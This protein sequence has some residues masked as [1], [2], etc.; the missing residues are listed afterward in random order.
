[1]QILIAPNAFKNALPAIDVAKFIL[2]GLIKSSLRFTHTIFPVA[3]GGDDTATLLINKCG[4][5]FIGALVKDPI[6]RKIETSFGISEDGGTAIIE[7]AAASG[8]KLLGHDELDPLHASTSGTGEL[9]RMALDKKVK[10]ILLC[11]GGSATIDGGS[12]ILR[13][14]GARFLDKGNT[15][16][17]GIPESLTHLEKIDLSQLDKRLEETEL[18]ILCDVNNRLLGDQGAAMIFGPQK[19]AG[20]RE[21]QKLEMALKRFTD[22]MLFQSGKDMSV[23]PHGGAAGGVAAGLAVI[24]GAE[25]VAGADFFLDFTDFNS[26]LQKADLVITGEGSIDPQTLQG[27]VPFAVA[28]RAKHLAIPVIGLAGKIEFDTGNQLQRYFDM[29]LPLADIPADLATALEQTGSNLIK[30]A[31]IIG[32]Y[33]AISQDSSK[34]EL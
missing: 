14:L 1:M 4:G 10:R 22:I 19:G 2:E 13:E 29:L 17:L 33:L 28:K 11:V 7:L 9:I 18:I 21:L 32:D 24:L 3:D 26:S 16:L 6:G 12:G 31:K 20:K 5:K 34:P 23:L 15:E 8:L 27:K 30:T 25:L